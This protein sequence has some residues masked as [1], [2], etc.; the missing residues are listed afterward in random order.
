M[1]ASFV[2]GTESRPTMDKEFAVSR[3]DFGDQ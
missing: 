2:M 1:A 3:E